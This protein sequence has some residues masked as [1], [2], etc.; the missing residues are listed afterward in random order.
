MFI[1]A[2]IGLFIVQWLLLGKYRKRMID[3]EMDYNVIIPGKIMFVNQSGML[4]SVNTMEGEKIKTINAKYSGW[5]GSFFN[6]GTIEIMTEGDSHTM[7]GSMPMYYVT[8]PNETGRQI[9]SMIDH[10]EH[11]EKRIPIAPSLPADQEHV[12]ETP[13]TREAP[14]QQR[15]DG[16]IGS[17]EVSYDVKGTVRDVLR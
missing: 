9:Q 10:T 4:S 12:V 1:F 14:T 13:T 15:G 6:F 7:L 2:D 16:K 17:R 3:L 5:L 11:E 8:A